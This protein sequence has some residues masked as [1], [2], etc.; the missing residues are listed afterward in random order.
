MSIDQPKKLRTDHEV[1]GKE[2]LVFLCLFTWIICGSDYRVWL[3][4]LVLVRLTHLHKQILSKKI[5]FFLTANSA[6]P[7]ESLP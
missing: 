7:K 3:N 4:K 6:Y 2:S 5:F 1:T